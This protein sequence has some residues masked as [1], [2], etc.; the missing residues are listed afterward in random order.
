MKEKE[1]FISIKEAFE[2]K[3]SVSVRGWIKRKRE[4]KG[5]IF[6][7]LRDETGELQCIIE[8]E[9]IAKKDFEDLQKNSIEASVQFRGNRQEYGFLKPA[10]LVFQHYPRL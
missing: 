6:I 7:L 5:K 10:K 3:G 4:L 9:K 8:P 2:E 1:K